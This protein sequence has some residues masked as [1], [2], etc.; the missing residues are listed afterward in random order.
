MR[1]T[2]EEDC[3]FAALTLADAFFAELLDGEDF[4]HEAEQGF[5]G[6]ALVGTVLEHLL[7]F[8]HVLGDAGCEDVADVV[9]GEIAEPMNQFDDFFLL[10][11]KQ[12]IEWDC[13]PLHELSHTMAE[14]GFRFGQKSVGV[15][16]GAHL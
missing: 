15:Q 7:G 1:V 11:A 16:S 6:D 2:C 8:L 5:C 4:G 12:C 13:G 9:V 14:V 10:F 3:H